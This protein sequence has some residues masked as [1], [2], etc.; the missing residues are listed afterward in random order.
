MSPISLEFRSCCERVKV[1][2]IGCLA[3]S[4]DMHSR[5][6]EFSFLHVFRARCIPRFVTRRSLEGRRVNVS[7]HLPTDD[8]ARISLG[9]SLLS[10]LS[11]CAGGLYQHELDTSTHHPR[12][13]GVLLAAPRRR[14][15]VR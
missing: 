9:V 10:P 2:H 7:V 1:W 4:R 5:L 14:Q 13:C 12:N 15:D 3:F 8:L 11:S 6:R